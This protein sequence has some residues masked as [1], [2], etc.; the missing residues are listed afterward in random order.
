MISEG[1]RIGLLLNF[2]KC[3]VVNSACVDGLVEFADFERVD[4]ESAC[5]L[6]APLTN[7]PAMDKAL[8]DRC[9]DLARGIDR[10]K[11]LASHDALV[12]LKASLSTPKLLHIMRSSPCADHEGLVRFDS[13]LRAGLSSILNIVISDVNWIQASLP[14][15]D[16]GLGIRSA[17]L[18]APSAF[19]A[20]AASTQDLQVQI[21]IHC[22]TVTDPATESTL[23]IWKSRYLAE[24]PDQAVARRQRCWDR[25]SIEHAQQIL[26]EHCRDDRDRARLAAVT[27]PHS[28]DWLHALPISSCGL[29]L[30]D[31]SIRIAVGLRLGTALC[32]PHL[33]PCG[34]LV[35][36]A[37]V[38][39]L[40]CR[41]SA[42]RSARHHQIND[43]VFRSLSRA[44]FPA[45]RE[46]PRLLKSDC[47]RPDG[48]TLIPWRE[49]K[50]LAWDA[51][52][53]DTF[54]PTYLSATSVKAGSAAD[55]LASKKRTKYADLRHN[56]YFCPI[57][58]ETMGPIEDEGAELLTS[59]GRYITGEHR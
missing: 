31:E 17:A 7:G 35:D 21:L 22:N 3:E 59:I 56:F 44:N 11:L 36:S 52:V 10:L 14:V 42:G 25:A 4:S 13:L 20:S 27:A 46:P 1:K 28:G 45:K 23:A 5:L 29:R 12:I 16:G 40:S 26:S 6:G 2:S 47:K 32:A 24:V 37:G 19:L 18:L 54:A 49:G 9:N 50:C 58:V 33:C 48:I 8:T 55:H 51:T 53:G 43:F 39:G 30:D 41:I 38:H 15:S 57:A 34:S